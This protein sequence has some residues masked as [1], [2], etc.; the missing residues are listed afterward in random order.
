VIRLRV[1][2]PTPSNSPSR[3][4]L[5]CM[6]YIVTST[7]SMLSSRRQTKDQLGRTSRLCILPTTAASSTETNCTACNAAICSLFLLIQRRLLCCPDL[8]LAVYCRHL[9]VLRSIH[10]YPLTRGAATH[11]V[12]VVTALECTC[13][14]ADCTAVEERRQGVMSV[15]GGGCMVDSGD[16]EQRGVQDGL[17]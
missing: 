4:T 3:H 17:D 12:V 8:S 16:V 1:C 13:R 15:E 11:P 7:V 5:F 2:S 9:D 10:S 14:R 6:S